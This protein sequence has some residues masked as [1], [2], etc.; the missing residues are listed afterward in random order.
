M[1]RPF[2]RVPGRKGGL[3]DFKNKF[4]DGFLRTI[5]ERT[6]AKPLFAVSGIPGTVG[7]GT[8]A[9]WKEMIPFLAGKREFAVS[10]L[11]VAKTKRDIRR[12]ACMKLSASRWVREFGV[13]LGDLEPVRADEDAF[14]SHFTAAAV[15]RCGLE[16]R[17]LCDR[18]WID[19]QA[20]GAMLLAG[21]VD[22][23][24][25]ARKLPDHPDVDTQV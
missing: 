10:Q 17:A 23:R 14:D 7:S 13:D 24:R 22:P 6:G 18:E 15:L 5:D 20:G 4:G 16:G 2:F 21:P 3:S 8:R 12:H 25:R 1:D 9:L 19:Y 11:K